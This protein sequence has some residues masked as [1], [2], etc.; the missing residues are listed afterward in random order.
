MKK[1]RPWSL[2]TVA[3]VL[4]ACAICSA[5]TVSS[6]TAPPSPAS[7]VRDS[8][9][10]KAL[11]ISNLRLKA[12]EEREK[13]LNDRLVAKD[14]I[15]RAKDG[16]IAIRDEQLEFAKSA[17]KDRAGANTV[18]QFRIEACQQQLSKADARIFSLE[19]PGLLKELFEPKQLIKIGGAFWL[20]RVTA[21]KQ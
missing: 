18:D 11:E 3:F 5:Q 15:I 21:P 12:A 20:G 17:N 19:H 4:S 13:L 9:T 6:T 14:E 7:P 8:E 1:L 16:L 10:L 2:L